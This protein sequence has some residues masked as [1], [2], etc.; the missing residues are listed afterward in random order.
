MINLLKLEPQKIS[1]DI[2]GKFAMTE[3]SGCG[4]ISTSNSA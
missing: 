2:R 4:K 3:Q 1:R